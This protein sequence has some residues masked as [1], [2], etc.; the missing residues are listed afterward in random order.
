MHVAFCW[1]QLE[2]VKFLF[3]VMV[4]DTFALQ[5]FEGSTSLHVACL[6]GQID[7]AR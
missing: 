3:E 2:V 1:G 6:H 5:D 4:Q 7:V